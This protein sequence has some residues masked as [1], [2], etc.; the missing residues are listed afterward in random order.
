MAID[1]HSEKVVTFAEAARLLPRRRAGRKPHISTLY[2]W[3][4]RGLRGVTLEIIQIGGTACTSREALQRF[5]DRLGRAKSV[6]RRE[7]P[8][9]HEM[10]LRA[11]ETFLRRERF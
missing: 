6:P 9:K 4:S 8:R 2:R 11:V 10:K 3:S 5:F 1:I 7:S